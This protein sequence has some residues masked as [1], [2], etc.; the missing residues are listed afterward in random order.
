LRD[1]AAIGGIRHTTL[2]YF[3]VAG[4]DPEGDIGQSTENATLLIKVACETALGKRP[5]LTLFGTDYATPDGTCIRDFIHVHDLAA[6]HLLALK[7]L[8]A[9]GESTTLNC[10]Y[11][12]GYSVREVIAAVERVHGNKLTVKESARRPG[13]P[14]ELVADS[15]RLQRLFDWQPRY[16]DLDTIV[17]TSLNWERHLLETAQP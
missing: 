4:S 6:V 9:G 16:A 3:N 14:P 13:D 15:A 10:G 12:H 1:L 17:T 8:R 2:R 7:Y 5:H 11:G